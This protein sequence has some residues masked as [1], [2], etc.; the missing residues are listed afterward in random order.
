MTASSNIKAVVIDGVI[1]NIDHSDDDES[2]E[3][4]RKSRTWGGSWFGRKR[5]DKGEKE[6]DDTNAALDKTFDVDSNDSNSSEHN[7]DVPTKRKKKVGFDIRSALGFSSS[8]STTPFSTKSQAILNDLTKSERE[9]NQIEILDH[10]RGRY[11]VEEDNIEYYDED[12]DDDEEEA[13]RSLSSSVDRSG[14]SSDNYSAESSLE[15]QITTEKTKNKKE[16]V[17]F[18]GVGTV[19]FLLMIGFFAAGGVIAYRNKHGW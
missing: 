14:G 9:M 11:I 7:N 15:S 6:K 17:L 5:K 10:E 19:L 12:Y 16:T 3:E 8:K 18:Y 1:A 4:E 2:K 13:G